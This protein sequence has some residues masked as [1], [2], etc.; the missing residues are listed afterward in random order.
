M[1]YVFHEL[2]AGSSLL[3]NNTQIMQGSQSNI[4]GEGEG[5]GGIKISLDF[6]KNILDCYQKIISRFP[7]EFLIVTYKPNLLFSKSSLL[8]QI[9]ASILVS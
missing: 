7:L 2:Y 9:N 3:D 5:G 1:V 8:N 4:D 6:H